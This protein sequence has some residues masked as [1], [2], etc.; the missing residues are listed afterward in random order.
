VSHDTCLF[1]HNED[2]ESSSPAPHPRPSH[3]LWLLLL[4]YH[5]CDPHPLHRHAQ[6]NCAAL[7]IIACFSR[8]PVHDIICKPDH[9]TCSLARTFRPV[10]SVVIRIGFF[11]GKN[12]SGHTHFRQLA[13]PPSHDSFVHHGCCPS[14]FIYICELGSAALLTLVMS[15]QCWQYLPDLTLIALVHTKYLRAHHPI[16]TH[17][18][19]SVWTSK[20]G[21]IQMTT[22]RGTAVRS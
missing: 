10:L 12:C 16:A 22:A 17:R 21:E 20:L 5:G 3:A 1:G 18:G 13:G 9:H 8:P 11:S 15:P 14:L 2:R 7:M 6:G 4:F 19:R